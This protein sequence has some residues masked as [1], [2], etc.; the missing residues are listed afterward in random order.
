MGKKNY[1]PEEHGYMP[2]PPVDSDGELILPF[3]PD[4]QVNLRDK[5]APWENKEA[6]DTTAKNEEGATAPSVAPVVPVPSVESETENDDEA[7][8][9]KIGAKAAAAG[10]AVA[11]VGLIAKAKIAAAGDKLRQNP[12]AAIASLAGAAVVAALIILTFVWTRP[13][14]IELTPDLIGE[15]PE[16]EVETPEGE[17][18]EQPAQIPE[19]VCTMDRTTDEFYG[20]RNFDNKAIERRITFTAQNI[21]N[22]IFVTNT[23]TFASPNVVAARADEFQRIFNARYP[24]NTR[25]FEAEWSHSK[26]GGIQMALSTYLLNS[27]LND[28][29]LRQFGLQPDQQADGTLVANYTREELYRRW[30]AEGFR[31]GGTQ[32]AQR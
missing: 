6:A 29:Q 5:F 21:P 19:L 31:C 4:E 17:T 7:A 2:L 25:G 18:V 10:A 24:L 22:Q 20:F 23:F 16:T 14:G 8:G 3:N 30:T 32:V 15:D 9:A 12:A 1:K 26:G 27:L 13:A 28:A 11:G